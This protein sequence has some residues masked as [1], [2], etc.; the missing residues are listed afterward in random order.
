MNFDDVKKAVARAMLADNQILAKIGLQQL[1]DHYAAYPMV[2]EKK[3]ICVLIKKGFTPKTAAAFS[4]SDAA[5]GKIL[6]LE[7]SDSGWT[8]IWPN[9]AGK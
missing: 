2:Q 5:N 7:K 8:K 9:S 3:S 1:A 4:E 6:V